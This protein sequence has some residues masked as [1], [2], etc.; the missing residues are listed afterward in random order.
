MNRSVTPVRSFAVSL[1][2]GGQGPHVRRKD[3]DAN[4]ERFMEHETNRDDDV[5][6]DVVS[7]LVILEVMPGSWPGCQ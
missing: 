7:G 4:R 2:R 6:N 5:V 1:Q 3:Y